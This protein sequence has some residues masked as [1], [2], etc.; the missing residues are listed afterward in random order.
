[1]EYVVK[2]RNG[3]AMDRRSFLKLATGLG[4]A[5]ATSA[6]VPVSGALA[7]DESSH[8][9]VSS[10]LNLRTGPGTRRKV[11]LVMPA[12]SIVTN[13]G[14]RKN[15]FRQVSYQGTVGWAYEDYLEVSNG[16]STDTPIPVGFGT[17]T[18]G[19]N[20]RAQ[21]STGSQVYQV[22]PE[23]TTVE[24]FDAFGNGFRMVGY[25][26]RTGWVHMDYLEEAGVP[27]GYLT[28][29]TSLNLREGPSTGSRIIVT[30][31]GGSSV[32]ATDELS[33]G[34]RRVNYQGTNGW[35]YDDYLS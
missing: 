11:I 2:G 34:F 4:L 32:R 13:V 33:N 14:G 35:A 26:N 6:V 24:V 7:V 29:S 20:F 12:G 31:P 23:G 8:Y 22:I 27:A 16:G 10:S 3:M 9:R 19:V 5:V 18:S 21:P 25:A 1:M 30:M 28:T 15:G 17:T